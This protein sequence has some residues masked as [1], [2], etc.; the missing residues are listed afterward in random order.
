MS[1]QETPLDAD[2]DEPLADSNQDTDDGSQAARS[3]KTF[4]R[5]P[6][7]L[8]ALEGAIDPKV[9]DQ[10]AELDMSDVV[11]R[12]SREEEARGKPTDDASASEHLEELAD[13]ML[14]L[15]RRM[16]KVEGGQQAII[17]QMA[18]QQEASAESARTIA[19]EVDTLR[20]DVVGDRKHTAA[21]SVL[22]E[23]IP[24]INRFETMYEHLDEDAD[25]RIRS[26]IEGV[27][28]TLSASLRRLGCEE[29]VTAS[30]SP[31]DPSRMQCEKYVDKGKPGHVVS[32]VKTGYRFGDFVLRPATV[33]VSALQPAT[34][35]ESG[36]KNDE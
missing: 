16:N 21:T 33:T 35:E 13:D 18:Q 28:D 30:G 36:D 9:F 1:E 2:Q 19:R 5:L 3:S 4:P 17:A 12:V 25:S 27:L 8:D 34:N 15:M 31:F 6:A 20:R 26:Q 7:G 10:L 11:E 29:F 23:L 22:N 32:T 24:L 14:N